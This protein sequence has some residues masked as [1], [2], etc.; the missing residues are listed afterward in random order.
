M[1]SGRASK[2]RA[3]GPTRIRVNQ[4]D[5]WEVLNYR[6]ETTTSRNNP[7]TI[8]RSPGKGRT[9]WTR[10]TVWEV[11]DRT[12]FGI[13]N[14]GTWYEAMVSGH[15]F[16]NSVYDHPPTHP[17]EEE[18]VK[19]KKKKRP[20][21]IWK[22][23]YRAAFLAEL[24]RMKGRGDA[25]TQEICV[26]CASQQARAKGKDK[27][28]LD[29]DG[30]AEYRC[31]ECFGGDMICQRC[32][33]RRHRLN[34][35]HWI[36]R[37]NGESFERTS[38]KEMGL[39]IQLNHN[40]GECDK[41]LPCHSRFRVLHVNGIHEVNLRFCDCPK[42]AMNGKLPQY[43]QLLRRQLYPATLKD[44]RILT[45][46]TF[47]YL[48]TLE[49]LGYTT[50]ASTY[51]FYRGMERLSNHQGLKEKAPKSR[52]LP[53]MVMIRQ[54]R[55]L[56]M[57]LRAGGG[58]NPEGVQGMK[59]GSLRVPCPSC[60]YPGVN[61]PFGWEN[62]AMDSRKR[63]CLCMDANFRLKEQL[64]SSFKN[65]PGLSQGLGY[66]VKREPYEAWTERKGDK[67][68]LSNCVSFAAISKQNTK[69]SKGLRYT[70][71]GGVVCAR[72]D[73]FVKVGNLKKGERYSNMDYI[74]A[75]ALSGM[76]PWM[77]LVALLL[78][79]DIA[80]QWFKNLAARVALWPSPLSL[81]SNAI[82]TPAI[83]KLHLPGHKEKDHE[84][85]NLNLIPGAAKIDGESN[86]R[87]W[88]PHNTLG[89]S[90]RTMGPGAREDY[91]E[92]HFDNWNWEKY[93]AMGSSLRTKHR[94]A[95]RDRN[96]QREAH[97]GLTDNLPEALVKQWEE[98]CVKWENTPYPKKGVL[99]PYATPEAYISVSKA[100]K[101][102]EEKE[103][104]Y[105]RSGGVSYHEMS[106]PAFITLSLE[107][108]DSQEKLREKVEERKRDPT[109]LQSAK[110]T[111]QRNALRRRIQV[112]ND[113]RPI[114]MPGLTQF[115]LLSEK[116][117][118]QDDD[119]CDPESIV[120]WLPS[121]IPVDKRKEVCR[122]DLAKKE[123]IIQQA[124][125]YD[126][127]NGLRH[128]LRIKSRM[129]HFKKT[130]VR[131]QRESGRSRAVINRVYAKARRF[132]RRYRRSRKAYLSLVGAGDWEKTL[133]V[134]EDRDV[135][136]Y[137]DPALVKQS[138]GR[139]GT[140]EEEE[141]EENHEKSPPLEL[142]ED[143]VDLI[144]LD[145]AE[146]AHRSKHGTGES[147]KEQ[148][149]IWTAGGKID[150][151]D[152]AEGEDNQ[153]L[154][155]EWCRSRARVKRCEEEV[156]LVQEE[157]RRTLA[158]LQWRAEEWRNWGMRWE[159]HHKEQPGGSLGEGMA[160]YAHSME[161]LQSRLYKSFE[162]LWKK[163]LEQEETHDA[164]EKEEAEGLEGEEAESDANGD[165]EEEDENEEQ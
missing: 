85:F 60:P 68:E 147:R 117:V 59:E 165:S 39:V 151:K 33:L 54:W 73:M 35:F 56:K 37:W 1:S 29:S 18:P 62:E 98:M 63:L 13:D 143:G 41:P 99:N 20:N 91:L 55:H 14:D 105:L 43:I 97:Q 44:S 75:S 126:T 102:L 150:V 64:V 106:A 87:T 69:F 78:I 142:D 74:M 89:N 104:E 113:V 53:L 34:P 65:D 28:T 124:R 11:E 112:L 129:M 10:D 120:I 125:C 19:K 5:D 24:L 107:I 132:A 80:C 72:T 17:Q 139:R 88:G 114:Y 158:F 21:I 77:L 92:G 8:H 95:V 30:K 133:R 130:N 15:V 42:K 134:L 110:I 100:L 149:W 86:E 82:I 81:P 84:Q 118:V 163:P 40:G 122:G 101:D 47:Q 131:G 12:D 50:K 48:N 94:D 109:S 9:L 159:Q 140:E 90:T 49:K 52:Y 108:Q 93:I 123:S 3:K 152:G 66:F 111:E 45:V 164:E 32:C 115:L 51:D 26:D 141:E 145:R 27:R 36:E 31:R 119:D 57:V 38:L 58:H 128:T 76:S 146:W 127:L 155:S 116:P 7:V 70:G 22:D 61:L 103:E 156:L 157:M 154:R 79:Y 83:G 160:S 121:D 137:S 46:A 135:R 6:S 96:V 162:A 16:D 25:R 67:D 136:G 161:G 153:V 148:S 138:K 71:V 4:S 2:R 144:P 23:Q